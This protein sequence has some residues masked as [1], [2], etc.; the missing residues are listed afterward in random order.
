MKIKLIK[1]LKYLKNLGVIAVKQLGR[2]GV[3]FND[4]L[5]MRKLKKSWT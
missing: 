1:K 3:G 5:L 4:L 2:R